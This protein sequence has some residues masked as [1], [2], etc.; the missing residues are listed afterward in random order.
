VSPFLSLLSD[1]LG[2][3]L[4]LAKGVGPGIVESFPD[5]LKFYIPKFV[6]RAG[7]TRLDGYIGTSPPD[8]RMA[9]GP[10]II[11]LSRSW[12]MNILNLVWM[13]PVLYFEQGDL[14][15]GVQ[16][17]APALREAFDL[18]PPDPEAFIPPVTMSKGDL[19]K[20]DREAWLFGRLQ[21]DPRT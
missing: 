2:L 18:L 15:A 16:R 20:T 19:W 21:R 5:G 4:G 14:E 9:E 6:T 8:N 11:D 17:F 3:E 10:K 13:L 12:D 1:C 7:I